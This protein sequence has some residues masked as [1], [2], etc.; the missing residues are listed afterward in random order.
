MTSPQAFRHKINDLAK[1]EAAK[2]GETQREVLTRIIYAR[3]IARIFHHTPEG[4]LVK[5]GQALLHRY[6]RARHTRDLDLLCRSEPVLD[7]AVA[8]LRAAVAANLD[9]D[10][11]RFAFY[12]QGPLD[13]ERHAVRV[14]FQVYLGLKKLDMISVDLVADHGPHGRPTRRPAGASIPDIGLNDWPDVRLYP[15]IDHIADKICALYE[16]HPSGPST[17]FR[18][19][20]DL[21]LMALREDL[22]GAEMHLALHAEATRRQR[23]GTV[24]SLPA[25][26]TIP[27]PVTWLDGYR[28]IA[29]SVRGLEDHRTL[30]HAAALA[31]RFISPLLGLTAPGRW[32]ATTQA[33]SS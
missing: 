13:G 3:L 25:V 21:V 24:V 31:D 29:R 20:A 30:G 17:R 2:T 15:V 7:D 9:G 27:D 19:L 16:Q 28:A 22:D 10:F 18:D 1:N 33:W 32:T 11:L 6:P 4:W 14:R 26:F 8:K 23:R 5:G 12:D